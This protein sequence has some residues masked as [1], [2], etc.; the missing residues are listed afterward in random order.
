[1]ACKLVAMETSKFKQCTVHYWFV[2]RFDNIAAVLLCNFRF[3]Q[4]K[5][6]CFDFIFVILFSLY[7]YTYFAPKLFFALPCSIIGTIILCLLKSSFLTLR[8]SYLGS[9][10]RMSGWTLVRAAPREAART[11]T[12]VVAI[13]S[14]GI[15]VAT[16]GCNLSR[17]RSRHHPSH[18]RHLMGNDRDQICCCMGCL[19]VH[20]VSYNPCLH[21]AIFIIL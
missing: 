16:T 4:M 19:K 5:A 13:A 1:M 21:R 18:R 14:A 9:A 10:K 17:A 20:F 2:K 8:A 3:T 7:L 15:V 6:K 11:C 12:V